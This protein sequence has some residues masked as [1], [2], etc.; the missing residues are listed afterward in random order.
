MD[1]ELVHQKSRHVKEDCIREDCPTLISRI[2]RIL[3]AT[4]CTVANKKIIKLQEEKYDPVFMA[5][6]Y[7][8]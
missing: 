1:R 6:G 8:G 4:V 3:F 5:L 7:F 2:S